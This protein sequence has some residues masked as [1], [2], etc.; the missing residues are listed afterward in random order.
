M[1]GPTVGETIVGRRRTITLFTPDESE[2]VERLRLNGMSLRRIADEASAKF[3]RRVQASTV[4]QRLIAMARD[5]EM[6]LDE[7]L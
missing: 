1:G 7:A 2:F 6:S 4:H 3:G 5:A